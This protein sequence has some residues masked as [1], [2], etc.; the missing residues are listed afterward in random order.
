MVSIDFLKKS[1]SWQTGI[2]VDEIKFSKEDV[3]QIYEW[4]S[5]V[6]EEIEEFLNSEEERA[7]EQ[8]SKG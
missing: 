7:N 8:Q 5:N 2:P 4:E 6:V 1:I 3:S